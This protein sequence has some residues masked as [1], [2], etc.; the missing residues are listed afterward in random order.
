M[1]R[2]TIN[3]DSFKVA[4]HA[5]EQG[6]L[7][8][9]RKNDN[10]VHIDDPTVSSHHAQ[11]VTVFDSS[12]IE[13]LGSTNGTFVNGQKTKT[14]TLHNG[15][16]VTI[17]QYQLLFQTDNS[18]AMDNAN[19]TMMMGVSQLEEL[20]KKARQT[21]SA[22]SP[23]KPKAAATTA[24]KLD[25]SASVAGKPVLQVHENNSEPTTNDNELPDIDD[26]TN[27]LDR[28]GHPVPAS[29]MRPLRK[30]DT[31]PLPSL[32]VIALAVLATIATFTLLM[33]FFQ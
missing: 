18:A 24:R 26:D 28:K 15:D 21:K 17:G 1:A 8:V 9:G 6:T 27:L 7:S 29:T 30:S 32:K 19:A 3:R 12:Y 4:E 13:D 33:F 20:T 16:I 2:I 11:I 25:G 23:S 22:T 5:L 14:H 31:S 10:A